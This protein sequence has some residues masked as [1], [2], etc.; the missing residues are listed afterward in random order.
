M[1]DRIEQIF[2]I[3]GFIIGIS[4]LYVA[5]VAY[6]NDI[7]QEKINKSFELFYI[8]QSG[9]VRKARSQLDTLKTDLDE[10]I[11][12]TQDSSNDLDKKLFLSTFN[13]LIKGQHLTNYNIM[14]DFY[15]AVYTCIELGACDGKT[16]IDLLAD[17]EAKPLLQFIV[18]VLAYRMETDKTHGLGLECIAKKYKPKYCKK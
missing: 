5:W 6:Q 4:A 10:A 12:K 2:T 1:L 14:L 9:E 8:Y 3:L 11:R 13:T 15:D 16:A 7:H 17:K 18:P